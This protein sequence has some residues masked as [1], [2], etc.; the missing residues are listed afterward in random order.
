MSNNR[1]TC[2]SHQPYFFKIKIYNFVLNPDRIN[3][4]AEHNSQNNKIDHAN[5]IFRQWK[6]HT[7][8]EEFH[9]DSILNIRSDITP[10]FTPSERSRTRSK[11]QKRFARAYSDELRL[12][13]RR[14]AI[15]NYN[16]LPP[17]S[18]Y[19]RP[20]FIRYIPKC[21]PIYRF[22]NDTKIAL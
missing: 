8:N 19:I 14:E 5:S 20:E 13:L 17:P 6:T 18:V 1:R 22:K 12:K 15:D 9:A 2:V 21:P 16:P 4:L 11:Q 3:I 7:I 10:T